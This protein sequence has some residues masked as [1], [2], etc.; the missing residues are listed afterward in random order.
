MR[1]VM[2]RDGD[3]FVPLRTRVKKA[4][5]AEADLFVSIHADAFVKPNA[6]GS[7]V[8]ALSERGAT[9]AAASW[10]AAKENE[11]DLIGGVNIDVGDVVLKEVLLDLS[12]TA[13]INESLK[14]GQSVLGELGQINKLHKPHVEQ[15]GFAVL[16][17]PD[18][19]SILVETAFLTNPQDI[20][21]GRSILHYGEFSEA[22]WHLLD[23]ITRPGMSV[24]EAGANMC[25]LT[26]NAQQ[27]KTIWRWLRLAM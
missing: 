7:S 25:T 4:R 20:Y 13:T 19:P 21:M 14:L 6:H 22:E 2:I 15:A 9:S 16:K 24:I 27:M 26:T 18:I 17:A 23:Q 5:E 1:A 8:F 12:Q 11:A 3:Y 10:L